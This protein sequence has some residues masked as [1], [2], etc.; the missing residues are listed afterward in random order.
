MWN[1]FPDA[2]NYKA[3]YPLEISTFDHLFPT[4]LSEIFSYFWITRYYCLISC[5]SPLLELDVKILIM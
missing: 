5:N 3:A 1:I 4:F 2:Q